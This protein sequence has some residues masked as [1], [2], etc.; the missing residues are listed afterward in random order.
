M[1][2]LVEII[3]SETRKTDK[4][5]RK[6]GILFT[7]VEKSGDV[8]GYNYFPNNIRKIKVLRIFNTDNM[9]L[10]LSVKDILTVLSELQTFALFFLNRLF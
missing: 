9:R 5:T 1:S 8:F 10:F 4:E 3:S 7:T 2:N 6:D